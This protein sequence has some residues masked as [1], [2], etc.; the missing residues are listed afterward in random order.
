MPL[1]GRLPHLVEIGRC[2]S[3]GLGHQIYRTVSLH[4]SVARLLSVSRETVR[5]PDYL[6]FRDDADY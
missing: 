3:V 6:N 2:F 5:G 4:I 1:D